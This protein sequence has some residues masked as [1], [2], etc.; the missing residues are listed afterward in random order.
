MRTLLQNI[1]LVQPDPIFPEH[2]FLFFIVHHPIHH[3]VALI[4]HYLLIHPHLPSTF[5]VHPHLPSIVSIHSP[6]SIYIFINIDNHVCTFDL[7]FLLLYQSVQKLL[8]PLQILLIFASD[9]IIHPIFRLSLCIHQPIIYFLIMVDPSIHSIQQ[10]FQF[11]VIHKQCLFHQLF[12]TEIPLLDIPNQTIFIFISS[13]I[14]TT[15]IFLHLLRI[16]NR[17]HI[18]TFTRFLLLHLFISQ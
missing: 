18:K 7:F 2:L 10:S 17:I 11:I 5:F 1:E 14:F 12:L 16:P 3:L 15:F 13:H 4:V 9:I 6:S 8:R